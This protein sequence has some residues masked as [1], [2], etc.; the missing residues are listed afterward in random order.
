M[1]SKQPLKV[2]FGALQRVEKGSNLIEKVPLVL[3]NIVLARVKR[4]YSANLQ[5][6]I[7]PNLQKRKDQALQ[8]T[9]SQAPIPI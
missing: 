4:L 1:T 8:P 6:A 9:S 5:L 3:V 2:L 7:E